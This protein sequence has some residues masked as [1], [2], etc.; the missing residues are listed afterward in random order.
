MANHITQLLRKGMGEILESPFNRGEKSKHIQVVQVGRLARSHCRS[1][2]DIIPRPPRASLTSSLCLFL[3]PLLV[4]PRPSRAAFLRGLTLA[5]QSHCTDSKL[6]RLE[7]LGS[8]CPS[9]MMQS[10][11]C[12]INFRTLGIPPISVLWQ[13]IN[14]SFIGTTVLMKINCLFP[15]PNHFLPEHPDIPNACGFVLHSLGRHGWAVLWDEVHNQRLTL[16]Q[17]TLAATMCLNPDQANRG[18]KAASG[19]LLI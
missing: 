10:Y 2:T 5:S 7:A 6:Q 17:L 18:L 19:Y 14:A 16:R 4:T 9:G 13:K 1:H 3:L 11:S 15:K 12:L 8:V